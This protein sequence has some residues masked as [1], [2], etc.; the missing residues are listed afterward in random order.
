MTSWRARARA[1]RA[2][3]DLVVG[4][5]VREHAGPLSWLLL[6]I[7]PVSTAA[8]FAGVSWLTGLGGVLA[9]L[10]ATGPGE[11]GRWS[12]LSWRL[13]AV[14]AVCAAGVRAAMVVPTAATVH[15]ELDQ[16]TLLACARGGEALVLACCAALAI[17]FTRATWRQ[18]PRWI[19]VATLL[20]AATS[21]SSRSLGGELLPAAAVGGVCILLCIVRGERARAALALGLLGVRIACF[22]E[23]STLVEA[24]SG[25]V[26]PA[27]LLTPVWGLL[28]LLAWDRAW[29]RFDPRQIGDVGAAEDRLAVHAARHP[30]SAGFRCLGLLVAALI[31]ASSMTGALPLLLVALLAA[32]AQRARSMT[33]L[34]DRT[35]VL[36]APAAALVVAMLAHRFIWSRLGAEIA[37]TDLL[38]ALVWVAWPLLAS[39]M[40]AKGI[41]RSEP[42]TLWVLTALLAI[43]LSAMAVF[44]DFSWLA[45][46]V[47]IVAPWLFHNVV[48]CPLSTDR[49][50]KLAT[51]AGFVSAV[52][53]IGFGLVVYGPWRDS[54]GL[55]RG[56]LERGSFYGYGYGDVD[57]RLLGKHVIGVLH[58]VLPLP[59]LWFLCAVLVDGA[60]RHRW[61]TVIP[62]DHEM[63]A[64]SELRERDAVSGD[65]R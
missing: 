44:S 37:A 62:A 49:V 10:L 47:G 58:H 13:V 39:I 56:R 64:W 30:W 18:G 51:R 3:R 9:G 24:L 43:A 12:C 48:A 19:G 50:F 42:R 26:T 16:M 34:F 31:L 5:L 17:I 11:R 8:T 25:G 41:D 22:V 45:I 28:V 53:A 61:R 40:V 14:L 23:F 7:G 57:A 46:G 35:A 59:I 2:D 32:D 33:S 6:L 29:R 55:P 38:S 36:I 60:R 54:L 63:S 21:F 1:L 15:H 4:S 52:L 20:A 65:G 27:L